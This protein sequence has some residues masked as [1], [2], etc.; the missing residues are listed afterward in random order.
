[1]IPSQPPLGRSRAVGIESGASRGVSPELDGVGTLVE[2]AGHDNVGRCRVLR[3]HHLPD[4]PT[5]ERVSQ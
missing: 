4:F 1:M 2:L 5:F 3:G